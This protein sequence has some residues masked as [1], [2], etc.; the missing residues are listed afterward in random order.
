MPA[1][2]TQSRWRLSVDLRLR[3]VAAWGFA[4]AL[5]AEGAAATLREV[6]VASGVP[7][8]GDHTSLCWREGP[9]YFTTARY[10]S[11]RRF[12]RLDT[13]HF[14]AEIDTERV[15]ITGFRRLPAPRDETAATQAA[16]TAE[17]LPAA[18][19][20]LGISVGDA[21]FSCTGRRKVRL[22]AHD[23]PTPPVDFPVRV[24]ESGR[25]FQKL[26]LHDLEFH[27]ATGRRLA[28]AARL[29][30]AA[31]PDRLTLTLILRPERTLAAAR[32]FLR[33]QTAHGMDASRTEAPAIWERA[34]EHRAVLTLAADGSA[35]APSPP[36]DVNVHVSATDARGTAT[37]RWNPEELCYAV[38]LTAPSWPIPAEGNYPESMLDAW[39][40]YP[41]SL[42]N[43]SPAPQRVALQ[44]EH[45]PAKS[46]TGFVPMLLDARDNPVGI[47][48]QVSKNWHQVAEG[49]DL[50]HAGPWMHGRTWINLAPNSRVTFRYGT[51]FALWGGVPT[52]SLA[53]LSLVGWGHN[54][55]W[56]EFALGA[57]GES[58]CFQPGRTM[59]RALLTDFRP[60][61][62]RGFAQ[63]ERWAWT[64]NVG[65]G[66]TMVR[67]DPQGRYVPFKRNVTR[68][69]SHGPNLAQLN[70]E[71]ISADAA[72]RSRVDVFLPRTDD[73]VRIFLRVRYDVDR[74]VRFSRLALF[75]LGADHYNEADAPLIAWG[76][77]DRF[78]G[79][80]RPRLEPGA[81][82]LPAW[83]A[84]GQQPWISI[85]GEPRADTARTGQ[86]SR[87]LIVREWRAR[88]GGQPMPAPFFAAVGSRGA[89]SRLAA[90]IIPPPTVNTLEAGDQIE[91][92]VEMIALPLSAE[93]YYGPD[94][95]FR[96][97]LATNANT[98]KM[99]HREAAANRATIRLPDGSHVRGWPLTVPIGSGGDVAFTLEGGLG[100]IPVRLTGLASPDGLDL[101]RVTRAG[102]ER[103][104]QGEPTRAFWQSDYDIRSARWTMT[105][106]LPT[107]DVPTTYVAVRRAGPL[108]EAPTGESRVDPVHR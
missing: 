46:I 37:V 25:F 64:S 89:K 30:I 103:V 70:Y 28:I 53:Q 88:V 27:D 81:R 48:V 23:Q 41:V 20:Q 33:L 21:A 86:A 16:L 85:H 56:D 74:R 15:A 14:A 58:F 26:A 29:E 1:I 106:N 61:Y 51:T 71:E 45:T 69:V 36:A 32:T 31:W 98:W 93:R 5:V 73:C 72:V 60:L 84:R 10:S 50:P 66:D 11:E 63:G 99:V 6:P 68:Y 87:G 92:L 38:R 67:L 3:V 59:R 108:I 2:N 94:G 18:R 101:L 102:R 49:I 75:Q 17:R 76:D 52:A 97:A 39:E 19:L 79:E 57:F 13:G 95:S 65:G 40:T 82:L 34:V 44:F 91:L 96:A 12:L 54:G 8:R 107:T 83:E 9:P 104:V 62:Q 77:V 55:F 105:Y 35:I 90:E 22:D 24:I 42:E 43:R 80:E 4:I 47:P 7:Q 100:W 78:N